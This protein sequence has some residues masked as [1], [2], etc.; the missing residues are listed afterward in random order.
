M[1]GGS[2]SNPSGGTINQRISGQLS[3]QSLAHF[4][5][6]FHRLPSSFGKRS[7]NSGLSNGGKISKIINLS[8]GGGSDNHI[9]P[10]T[11]MNSSDANM[12]QSFIYRSNP[13]SD[14]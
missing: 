1:S 14:R 8:G 3:N 11:S 10:F 5:K 9:I 6:E 7:A 12:R 2:G 4:V 13:V